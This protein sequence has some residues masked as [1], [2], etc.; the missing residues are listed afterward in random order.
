MIN[1]HQPLAWRQDITAAAI[2]YDRWFVEFGQLAYREAR[3]QAERDVERLL[4]LT[5]D[6]RLVS[7]AAIRSDPASLAILRMSTAPPLA[8]DRLVTLAET[9]RPVVTTLERGRLPERM[10]RSNLDANLKRLCTVVEALLD[11]DFFPWLTLGRPPHPAE[12]Q[13]AVTVVADRRCSAIS[14][15]VLRYAQKRRQHAS[16]ED[17]LVSRGYGRQRLAPGHQDLTKMTPRTYAV[18]VNVVVGD[19]A[20]LDIPVDVVIQS[21]DPE[22]HPVLIQAVSTDSARPDRRKEANRARLLREH[23]GSSAETL[24][25]LGGV[26]DPEYLRDRAA[27]GVDWVWEHRISDL[28]RAG[29]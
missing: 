7:P 19:R 15:Q 8:R 29:I 1:A 9:Q 14:E 16:I 17:W 18:G 10:S 6:L 28:A 11:P 27:E 22:R 21:G 25:L 12:R 26:V 4:D 23:L 2:S 5:D 24:L 3:Q 13:Y 20:P